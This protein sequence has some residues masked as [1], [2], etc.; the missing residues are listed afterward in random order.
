MR[1]IQ[2]RAFAPFA[3]ECLFACEK[4]GFVGSIFDVLNICILHRQ[5]SLII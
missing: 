4:L 2:L 1:Q 3:D 5:Y